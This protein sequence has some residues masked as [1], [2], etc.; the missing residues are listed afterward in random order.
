[1]QIPKRTST[2]QRKQRGLK[3]G[4]AY[5][6]LSTLVV[7][8]WA[9][10]AP[11]SFFDDFP[12][13]GME[14]VSPF[15][16]YN[17]HLIRDVGGLNLGFALLFG[18]AVMALD[19]RIVQAVSVGYLAFSIPHFIFHIFHLETLDTSEAILQTVALGSLVLVPVVLLVRSGRQDRWAVKNT[20][21]WSGR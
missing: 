19:R 2:F 9:L 21:R 20:T 4:L 6:M 18:W 17:E 15:P 16:R 5:L 11:R 8:V 13:L 1:L 12:G 3:V 10:L 14:W 7:G